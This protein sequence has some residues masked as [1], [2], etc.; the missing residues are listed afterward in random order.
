L[1]MGKLVWLTRAK[2][3]AYT[4]KTLRRSAMLEYIVTVC[5]ANKKKLPKNIDRMSLKYLSGV[6]SSYLEMGRKAK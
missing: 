5:K 6:Y 2:S 3:L 4:R 1:R